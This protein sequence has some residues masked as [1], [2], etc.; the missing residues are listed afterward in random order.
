MHGRLA[1]RL[2]DALPPGTYLFRAEALDGAGQL[3]VDHAPGRRHRDD[4]A[5][6]ACTP[7]EGAASR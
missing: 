7:D 3:G 2:P 1:A 5:Q 4:P 6:A